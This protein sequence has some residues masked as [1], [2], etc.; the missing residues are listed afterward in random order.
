M[1]IVAAPNFK[2]GGFVPRSAGAGASPANS[3]LV[4]YVDPATGLTTGDTRIE[5]YLF[6]NAGI[7]TVRG[8]VYQVTFSGVVAKNPQ[9]IVCATA[10]P[11]KNLAVA[12]AVVADQAWGWFAISGYVDASLEATTDIVAGDFLK[13]TSG[14]SALAFIKDGAAETTS[15]HATAVAALTT[16]GVNRPSATVPN[17]IYLLGGKA[18]VA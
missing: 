10:T 11:T 4:E 5:A 9:V 3:R 6:N 14:T 2:F 12:V 18:L 16:D 1:A 8:D 15:S 7:P 13:L 17:K